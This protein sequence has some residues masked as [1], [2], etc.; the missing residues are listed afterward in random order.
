MVTLWP[1]AWSTPLCEQPSD[2]ETPN[3]NAVYTLELNRDFTR[4][5]KSLVAAEALRYT[6]I[7]LRRRVFAD[8][9]GFMFSQCQS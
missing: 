8:D 5:E 7:T 1:G 6:A 9:Q 2:S 4:L 3:V